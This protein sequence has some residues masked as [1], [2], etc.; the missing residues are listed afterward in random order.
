MERS[1]RPAGGTHLSP[2]SHPPLRGT[3][4]HP[5][6]TSM[7]SPP[8]NKRGSSWITTAAG[9]STSDSDGSLP[10]H[11]A[12][13]NHGPTV[14]LLVL[15]RRIEKIS[16]GLR[17]LPFFSSPPFFFL[18]FFIRSLWIEGRGDGNIPR[19]IFPLLVLLSYSPSICPKICP[20]L[21]DI[22]SISTLLRTL[23]RSFKFCL[24]LRVE[25]E[26]EGEERSLRSIF[27]QRRIPWTSSSEQI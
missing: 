9:A 10:F 21:G 23:Q 25:E 14:V 22:P 15:D 16:V 7:D 27:D 18:S 6:T 17:L 8:L 5:A 4:I 26:E 3:I 11:L 24:K 20:N 2:S 1:K 19:N 12:T 13:Y